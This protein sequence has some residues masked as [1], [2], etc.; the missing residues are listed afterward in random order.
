MNR[1]RTIL[2]TLVMMAL[3]LVGCD[4]GPG[5]GGSSLGKVTKENVL[6]VTEGTSIDDAVIILGPPTIDK[7]GPIEGYSE[8]GNIIDGEPYVHLTYDPVTRKITRRSI[9]KFN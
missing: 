5:A 9:L 1:T 4:R 3:F 7:H 6:K 8:W 2:A